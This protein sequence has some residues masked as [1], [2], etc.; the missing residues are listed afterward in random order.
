MDD[1]DFLHDIEAMTSEERE[2]RRLELCAWVRRFA[3]GHANPKWVVPHM[4]ELARLGEFVAAERDALRARVA[5]LEVGPLLPSEIATFV[6]M[7]GRVEWGATDAQD[8]ASHGADV[9]NSV[10]LTA[11]HFKQEG[12]QQL[13]GLYVEGT[14]VVVCH[15]GTSPNT[16]GIAQALTGAWNLLHDRA[17]A[18]ASQPGGPGRW[19]TPSPRACGPTRPQTQR[20]GRLVGGVFWPPTASTPSP[21]R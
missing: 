11:D 10:R 1:L 7:I 13:H 6:R 12:P 8:A 21:P 16:P 9:A 2:A 19:V 3:R 20:P 5:E 4:N 14:H 18:Q 15:T 17:T